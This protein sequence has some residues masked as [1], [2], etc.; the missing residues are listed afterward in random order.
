MARDHLKKYGVEH[1]WDLA[2]SESLLEN[3]DDWILFL[4]CFLCF[5][6][7]ACKCKCS[8]VK[9]K[10]LVKHIQET[11]RSREG[12]ISSTVFDKC[13]K[14]LSET[15]VSS[16]GASTFDTDENMP[17]WEYFTALSWAVSMTK[18]NKKNARL[19]NHRE[20]VLTDKRT[21]FELSIVFR[22]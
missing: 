10:E 14:K 6:V 19:D 20:E 17:P 2:L 21:L 22:E 1:Y 18:Q 4:F 11:C 13:T 3:A 9:S 5:V 12:Q 7:V 15:S 16:H 8:R